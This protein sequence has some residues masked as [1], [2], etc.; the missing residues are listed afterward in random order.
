MGL[1]MSR[2]GRIP[3]ALPKDVK[4]ACDPSK[5]EVTGPKG[6]LST[7]LPRGISVAVDG[8]KISI[9]RENDERSAKALHGLTRSLIS[10]MVTGVTKGFDKGIEIVGVSLEEATAK[11]KTVDL[12][13]YEVASTFFS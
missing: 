3:I 9:Q 12:K 1:T 5:V 4:V 8:G 6:R 10:N 13:L 11:L 7:S 2:I